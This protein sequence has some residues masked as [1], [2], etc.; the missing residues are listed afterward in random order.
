MR[1][2]PWLATL[3]LVACG[4]S[5]VAAAP[6]ASTEP[7][8]PRPVRIDD[9]QATEPEGARPVRLAPS[10]PGEA[11]ESDELASPPPVEAPTP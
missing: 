1:P 6:G 2:R 7:S 9:P 11:P 3:L 4:G 5:S 10:I 8:G